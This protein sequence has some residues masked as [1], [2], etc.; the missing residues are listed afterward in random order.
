MINRRKYR[1][2]MPNELLNGTAKESMEEAELGCSL[3]R[4]LETL[5]HLGLNF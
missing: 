3:Y 5:L 4:R 2:E 1:V